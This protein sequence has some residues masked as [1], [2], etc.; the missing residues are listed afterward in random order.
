MRLFLK[1][2]EGLNPTTLDGEF[3]DFKK[4]YLFSK[5]YNFFF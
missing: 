1:F 2:L 4:L 5:N 3:F